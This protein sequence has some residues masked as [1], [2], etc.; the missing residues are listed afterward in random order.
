MVSLT[1][2]LP[3]KGSQQGRGHQGRGQQ[4]KGQQGRGWQGRGQYVFRSLLHAN[5]TGEL[6]SAG[7]PTIPG[8]PLCDMELWTKWE[9]LNIVCCYYYYLYY[10]C[11]DKEWETYNIKGFICKKKILCSQLPKQPWQTCQPWSFLIPYL[12]YLWKSSC[13]PMKDLVSN[14]SPGYHQLVKTAKVNRCNLGLLQKMTLAV[15][16]LFYPAAAKELQP[17]C[18]SQC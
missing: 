15:V 11:V 8:I 4:G 18:C 16:A 7:P 13:Y 2:S 9:V 17:T 14:T 5:Q 1:L 3:Q 12:P 6:N 10:Y